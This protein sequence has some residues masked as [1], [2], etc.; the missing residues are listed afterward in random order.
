MEQPKE[1]DAKPT[2]MLKDRH[3]QPEVNGHG[4]YEA[5]PD[6][7]FVLSILSH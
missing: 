1:T 6:I 4:F 5:V 2:G 7:R 3:G